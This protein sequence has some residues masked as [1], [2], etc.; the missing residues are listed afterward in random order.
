MKIQKKYLFIISVPTIFLALYLIYLYALPP[1]INSDKMVKKYESFLSSKSGTN[2]NLDGFKLK[3]E[4]D[5]SISIRT[6]KISA[7]SNAGNSLLSV[8][9]IFYKSKIFSVLPENISVNSIYA[10]YSEIKKLP[11]QNNKKSNLK[12]DINYLPI[13]N[14]KK[15][16]VKLDKNQSFINIDNI[17]S[18]VQNG[19]VNCTFL[20]RIKIPYLK[21]P[22]ITGQ[23]GKIT[24]KKKVYFDNLSVQ[25]KNSK[26]LV[27]GYSDNLNFNGYNL[28]VSE[29]E[30]SFLYFYKLK[31]PKKKNFI[32]NFYNMSGTLDLDLNLSKSG[33]NGNCKGKKLSALFSNYKIPVYLPSTD[34]KFSG[35]EINA[36]TKGT[37]GG[38]P[39]HTDFYLKGLGTKNLYVTG[40]VN[41]SLTNKFSKKY[42][43]LVSIS[44]C[45]DAFVRYITYQHKVNIDYRLTLKSGSNIVSDYGSL[46]NADKNRQIEAITV[47]SGEKINLKEFTY[48]FMEKGNKIVLLTGNG[49]FEKKQGHYKPSIVSLKTYKPLPVSLLG[50]FVDDYIDGGTFSADLTYKFYTKTLEGALDL[51][52][53]YHK[54]YLFIKHANLNITDDKIKLT[55]DGTFFNSPITS[56]VLLD[57]NFEK[58]ILIRDVDIHLN[59]F[60]VKRGELKN[61]P[62]KYNTNKKTIKTKKKDYKI[63]VEKGQIL[64]DEIYHRKF[65]LKNVKI[66]GNLH[67]NKAAFI[68]KETPYAK[69]LLS[70]TGWYDV[71]KHSSDIHFYASD[72]DSNEV[73]TN[74]LNFKNQIEGSAFATLHLK[75]KNKLNDIKAHATFAVADGYLPQLGSTE[76]MVGQSKKYKILNKLKKTWTFSLSKITNIDFS[77][78]NVFYSNLRGSFLL[79]NEQIY[80]AKIF[81]Q[82]D[83]LSLFIEGDYNIDSEQADICIWGRHNKTEEKK[84]RIFKIP[85]T[86]IYRLVFRVERTKDQYKDKL[87]QIPA[88][89]V[90]PLD[91]ESIFRVSVCG[92]LNKGNVK[93]ILK[94]LR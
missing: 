55:T 80:N 42:F 63:T 5:F 69:G 57:N 22:I 82:S 32:E 86:F 43:P 76:F 78:P 36:D 94:D 60:I 47:K 46:N 26:I 33:L 34:F 84:I 87:A 25:S 14:I 64:V 13:I 20:A 73:A 59:K 15:A 49:L 39:V 24:Y 56:S 38:E 23:Q 40:T 92:N 74:I 83:Y 79:N 67:D 9:K 30:N 51:Y 91:V 88:I 54:D 10:D 66:T 48:S 52:N 31:H 85:L 53:A 37:F 77:K 72:I 68:I 16:F 81:S 71:K 12:L 7:N 3:T 41:S 70:A 17:H 27:S 6:E 21:S 29:L 45:A 61:I 62:S 75:T 89:K 50:T 58:E 2:V 65:D 11:K 35:R 90:K 8:D 44:G 93:I 28:Q 18:E 19:Q 4:P 1:I